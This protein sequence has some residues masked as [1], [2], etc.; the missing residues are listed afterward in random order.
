MVIKENK[1]LIFD[2]EKKFNL[3]TLIKYVVNFFER[4]V[5][6]ILLNVIKPKE[7][8]NVYKYKVSICAIF[9]D[10]ADYIKE[11]IEYHKIVGVE[12]FYLYNNNSSDNYL[13][14]LKSY[15][16]NGNVTLNDWPM[17]QGQ[18]QAYQHWADNY[19][20]ESKWVGFIDL[21]EFVVPNNANNIYDF[22]KDFK[23]RPVVVIYWRY[24]GS[25]GLK[26]RDIKGLVTE[27]FTIGW[28]KY[29]DI[30]KYFFNTKYD[31]KQDFSRNRKMHSM[32][33][34][35]KGIMLPPVN[36]FDKVCTCGVNPV[37][38][39]IM[40]IQINHY[41]LKSYYEYVNRK[42]KKGGG[43]NPLGIHDMEYFRYHDSF[44]NQEDI[45]IGKYL[46]KLK[47]KMQD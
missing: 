41:L 10:E 38:T 46:G 23:N 37:S 44:S 13:E 18:M 28:Y 16:D 8:N 12:H 5:Y 15:I 31:Y 6:G 26:T 39:D 20:N 43:V 24:F 34:S 17:K 40:P 22:L 4:I 21:D 19:K 27:D 32:W 2:V 45:H 30:G 33:G 35:Y 11:W 25:S 29:A 7:T 36:V 1:Y 47:K 42:T 9:K 3:V 14:I